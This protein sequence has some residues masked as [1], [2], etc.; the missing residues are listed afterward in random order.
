[1]TDAPSMQIL[2]TSDFQGQLRRLAKRY[3]NIRSDL[4]P[5][6]NDLER[7]NCPGDQIS[8]TTYTVFK[9]RVKNSD[10]QKGKSAGYRVIYQLRDNICVLLVTIYSKSDETTLAASEIREIIDRFNQPPETP[11]QVI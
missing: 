3:R 6:F 4:Q 9:V 5:L 8:G 7:G 1:M 10:I 2:V 11:S